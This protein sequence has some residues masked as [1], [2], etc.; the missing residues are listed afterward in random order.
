MNEKAA[1]KEHPVLIILTRTKRNIFKMFILKVVSI[2][3][4]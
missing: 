3:I 1:G 2:S 4:T